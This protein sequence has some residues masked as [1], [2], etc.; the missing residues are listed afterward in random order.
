[1]VSRDHV[2]LLLLATTTTA[3][4]GT[5]F[6]SQT[7]SMGNAS[8]RVLSA[9][10]GKFCKDHRKKARECETEAND[11]GMNSPKRTESCIIYR[12]NAQ[13]CAT[14]VR[15]AFRNINMS[16]C[17]KEIK[18]LTLCED[19]WCHQQDPS[20]CQKECTGVRQRLSI[21]VQ[22]RVMIFFNQ[23]EIN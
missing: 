20:F 9:E 11:S 6:T 16:G 13:K 19:E 17:P 22:Q 3:C 23:Y 14:V 5:L 2:K 12:Q 4:I 7:I 18:M 15:M 21:C 1:M 8:M 10:N